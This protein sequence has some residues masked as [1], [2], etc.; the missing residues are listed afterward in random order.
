M[1]CFVCDEDSMHQANWLVDVGNYKPLWFVYK[2][3]AFHWTFGLRQFMLTCQRKINLSIY[4]LWSN[5]VVANRWWH[6]HTMKHFA[7]CQWI[8]WL[9]SIMVNSI[10]E[11]T[12]DWSIESRAIHRHFKL[13]IVY[14]NRWNLPH[15]MTMGPRDVVIF[16]IDVVK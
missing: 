10:G 13:V 7:H 6:C 15:L 5:W 1:I 9:S 4:H 14:K 11:P 2:I 16:M 12:H 3:V 8:G